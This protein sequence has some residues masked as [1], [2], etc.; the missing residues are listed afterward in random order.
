M[1]ER[2]NIEWTDASWTPIRAR[3]QNAG[4]GEEKIG[5]HC[6]HVSE[7]CR[8]CYAEAMNKRFGTGLPYK[9]GHRD[10]IDL[11]LNRGTLLQPIKWRKPRKIFVCSMTDLFGDWVPDEWIDRIFTVMVL[12]PQHTFQILTKRSERMRDYISTRAGD[13]ALTLSKAVDD[14]DLGK[15]ADAPG[16]KMPQWPLPNVWLGVTAENQEQADARIPHLLATP[17]AVRFVS[18]EPMFEAVDLR[19]W[20]NVDDGCIG[21]DD[22]GYGGSTRCSRTDIPREEQCPRNFSVFLYP[23]GPT[24]A[25][26]CP[27]WIGEKKITLDWV[28]V[29]SESGQRER[30]RHCD[31][32]WVRSLRN[33][34]T[35]ASVPFFF[36]QHVENGRKITLPELDGKS[37]A[38]FPSLAQAFQLQFET[39]WSTGVA[40]RW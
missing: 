17:A 27:E 28:I 5:W 25:D 29:G 15:Y 4:T 20:L 39:I 24:D 33:Q 36:K 6:E 32:D 37:W 12:A 31:L 34:C 19:P 38:E 23:E 3:W 8:N 1:A 13:W 16:R 7:A 10:E 14:A 11:F 2:S 18:I 35:A 26:G 22:G 30:I 21:C 9:P 40:A